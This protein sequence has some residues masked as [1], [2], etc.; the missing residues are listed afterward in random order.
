MD[1]SDTHEINVFRWWNQGMDAAGARNGPGP[2][3]VLLLN[4]D[5]V[6]GPDAVERLADALRRTGAAM[7]F[8]GPVWATAEDV[9]TEPGPP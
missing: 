1:W 5:V 2:H 9:F 4:D 6:L 3:N 7:A 8:P